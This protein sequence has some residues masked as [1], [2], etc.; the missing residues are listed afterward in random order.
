MQDCARRRD[1]DLGGDAQGPCFV[2]HPYECDRTFASGFAEALR[3]RDELRGAEVPPAL[4]EGVDRAD[5]VFVS[6]ST[7]CLVERAEIGRGLAGEGLDDAAQGVVLALSST[8]K[9]ERAQPFDDVIVDDALVDERGVV[10]VRPRRPRGGAER[11]ELV[12]LRPFAL[13]DV[14]CEPLHQAGDE[15]TLVADVLLGVG[16]VDAAQQRV[17]VD[18][19]AELALD[20]QRCSVTAPTNGDEEGAAVQADRAVQAARFRRDPRWLVFTSPTGVMVDATE[21]QGTALTDHGGSMTIKLWPEALGVPYIV[22][23]PPTRGSYGVFVQLH[24]DGTLAQVEVCWP[25][26]EPGIAMCDWLQLGGEQG[27]WLAR[28]GDVI[29]HPLGIEHLNAWDDTGAPEAYPEEFSVEVWV[30]EALEAVLKHAPEALQAKEDPWY[31]ERAGIFD[32]VY[33][34]NALKA[35]Q[36]AGFSLRFVQLE[37]V[38][39]RL[40][41]PEAMVG[42]HDALVAQAQIGEINE[43]L[44]LFDDGNVQQLPLLRSMRR[45]RADAGFGESVVRVEQGARAWLAYTGRSALLFGPPAQPPPARS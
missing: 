28:H 23:S 30:L 17:D 40:T 35:L 24:D 37:P 7:P 1:G 5:D 18:V 26:S 13:D 22:G 14:G 15:T 33:S 42:D 32:T 29:L 9:A 45:A 4:G 36:G 19:R 3:E 2:V 11:S 12:G 20:D 44:V 21:G 25:S 6:A 31:R 41:V 39:P 10:D 8:V 34:T 43:I 16:R 27:K 38:P